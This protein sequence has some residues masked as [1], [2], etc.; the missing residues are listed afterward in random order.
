[1]PIG[2][3]FATTSHFA[4]AHSGDMLRHVID[5]NVPK[6]NVR[7]ELK[8]TSGQW[9]AVELFLAKNA[10]GHHGSERVEDVL[11]GPDDFFPVRVPGQASIRLISREKVTR[12][13]LPHE[14]EVSAGDPDIELVSRHEVDLLLEDGES[15]RG[16]VEFIRPAGHARLLDFLNE[17][18]LFFRFVGESH[19]FL[20][21]KY[22]V[23]QVDFLAFP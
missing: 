19:S 6:D 9:Q 3:C 16:V 22:H 1:M 17:G 14:P 20:I 15:L 13:R 4:G 23:S 5:V 10:A 12:V 7:L 2:A 8:L 18:P 21:N 11:N